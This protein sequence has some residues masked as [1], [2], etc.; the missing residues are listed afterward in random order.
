M[1]S[2]FLS[3]NH[4]DKAF[5]KK[6]AADLRLHGHIVWID[7][8]EIEV[9]DSLVQ[10]IRDGID[11]VD[12]LAAIV[13]QKSLD[14]EWVKKELDLASN[15]EIDEKRVVVLPLLLEDVE[16]PGFLKGKMYADFRE[17]SNYQEALQFLLRKLGP[18]NRAP[19]VDSQELEKLRNELHEMKKA[20]EFQTR[21]SERRHRMVR[22]DRSQ[23][24]EQR[25]QVENKSKPEW[26]EINNNY[27][28]EAGGIPVTLG[29]MFHAMRKEDIKGGHPL[30]VI[31][32]LE[33]KWENVR[34]MLEAFMDY[35]GIHDP[36]GAPTG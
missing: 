12:F 19:D 32:D 9:G 26:A 17:E 24:L 18:S 35:R 6:L 5:A 21:E 15:R 22:L 31:I 2:I 14:S 1:S 4:A 7:E 29:Y 25:I 11:R 16:L 30:A 8:A 33:N 27:A 13:S 36:P 28:F 34:L 20:V 3:H 10:K 23:Q